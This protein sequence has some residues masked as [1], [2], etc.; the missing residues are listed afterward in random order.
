MSGEKKLPMIEPEAGTA[1]EGSGAPPPPVQVSASSV[2]L[3]GTLAI[4]GALAGMA[5]VLAFQWAKPRIDAYRA[6]VLN[7]AIN[8]VLG[9]PDHYETV[10]LVDGKFTDQPPDTAGRDRVY[11]GF[12][13]AGQP[14]GVAI[15]AAEA[16]FQDI[17]DLIFGYDPGTG[18]VLGMKVL[19]SKETPGLGDKITKDSTFIRE[20]NDVG[21]P[22]LGVKKGQ[23]SGGHDEVV[24]ITGATISSRA[25]IAIIN[26]RLEAIKGPVDSYW[27]SPSATKSAGAGAEGAVAAAGGGS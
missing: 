17:I 10:Y 8:E 21:T 13:A 5:I 9:E 4:A 6:M 3:I 11:V 25:V 15:T 23:G 24:M 22:L 12:D 27:S 26:D 2:R 7:Q 14:K 20:F 18:D 1:K 16:G 19:E